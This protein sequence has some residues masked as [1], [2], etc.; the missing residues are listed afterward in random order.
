MNISRCHFG[1]AGNIH[2]GLS[3]TIYKKGSKRNPSTPARNSLG[4]RNNDYSKKIFSSNGIAPTRGISKAKNNPA[5]SKG[6]IDG[7]TN[8]TTADASPLAK[9][10]I[11][12][13]ERG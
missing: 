8:V 1:R 6:G 2:R 7:W 4:N 5:R 13:I 12:S 11:R 10:T 3:F 9:F